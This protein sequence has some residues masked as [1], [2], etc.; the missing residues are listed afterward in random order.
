LAVQ[1]KLFSTIVIINLLLGLSPPAYCADI[2]GQDVIGGYPT[3]LF[4]QLPPIIAPLRPGSNLFLNFPV[5]IGLDR[6]PQR[7]W[8]S[9]T[10]DIVQGLNTNV[11]QTFSDRKSGYIFNAAPNATLGYDLGPAHLN[12]YCTYRAAKLLDSR[13]PSQD[14]PTPQSVSIGLKQIY[15]SETIEQESKVANL[16]MEARETWSAANQRAFQLTPSLQYQHALK[17]YGPCWN[18]MRDT[19]TLTSSIQMPIIM[20][21]IPFSGNVTSIRPIYSVGLSQQW[22]PWIVSFTP[23]LTTNYS[24]LDHQKVNKSYVN[25]LLQC[26]VQRVIKENFLSVFVDANPTWYGSAQRAAG[27]SG[28]G[29]QLVAGVRVTLQKTPVNKSVLAKL[30]QYDQRKALKY[31]PD[32][33]PKNLI[34]QIKNTDSLIIKDTKPVLP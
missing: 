1:S 3:N 12:A 14:Y 34:R 23:Q 13:V 15:F 4:N 28:Y 26:E 19:T 25:G 8:F 27:R 2:L 18:D 21:Q 20:Q 33:V 11:L 10:A 16:N 6:L 24:L 5:P 9:G 22:V 30:N 29:F 17:A 31:D 7:M 32:H